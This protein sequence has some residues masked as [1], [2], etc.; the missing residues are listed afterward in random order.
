[1]RRLAGSKAQE[2]FGGVRHQRP[3][4]DPPIGPERATPAPFAA[5]GRPRTDRGLRAQLVPDQARAI[6]AWNSSPAPMRC[7]TSV[8]R[9]R[10]RRSAGASAS[11]RFGRRGQASRPALRGR[12]PSPERGRPPPSAFSAVSPLPVAHTEAGGPEMIE[13]QHGGIARQHQVGPDRLAPSGGGPGARRHRRPD[14]TDP[15][16]RTAG[17]RSASNGAAS[18]NR[19]D[20]D[21]DPAAL[22]DV[23]PAARPNPPS[24]QQGQQPVR[25]RPP[26]DPAATID[27]IDPERRRA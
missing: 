5:A 9:R 22:G 20:P 23:G 12:Q 25:H 16:G 21:H 4:P 8:D 18:S 11:N 19:A 3:I 1:M 7:T 26:P 15:G 10:G 6:L 13:T 14:P 17:S 24:G 27:R 2:Q